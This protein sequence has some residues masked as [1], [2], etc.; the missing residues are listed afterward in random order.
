MTLVEAVFGEQHHLLEQGFCHGPIN[1]PLGGAFNEEVLVF[2]HL[3]FLLF[4]HRPPQQV[5]LTQR[6][7]RQILG[8]AHDLLL[9]NH[10]PVGFGQDRF[11]LD[12]GHVDGFT[13][14]LAVDE[15]GNQ[16][17]IQGAGSIQGKNRRN[18]FQ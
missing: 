2:F 16:A 1:A 13:A 12:V 8:N 17:R 5:G 6:I 10:D 14:M 7:A 4:A 15:F 9:I 18:I 3:A 11:E